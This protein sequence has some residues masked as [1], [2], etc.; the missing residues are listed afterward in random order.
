MT[1][2]R[3]DCYVSE[4]DNKSRKLTFLHRTT[5]EKYLGRNLRPDEHVHHIDGN[6]KNNEL[7]NL[8]VL[9]APEHCKI[10]NPSMYIKRKKCSVDG[11]CNKH[12]GKVY[13]KNH[14]AK[15]FRKKQVW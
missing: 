15:S 1:T 7:S 2:M 14:Y 4:W 11:C 10:H 5:M 8:Q 13:C 12:H 9:T 6:H 3:M